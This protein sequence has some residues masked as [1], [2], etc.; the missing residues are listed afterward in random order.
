MGHAGAPRCLICGSG[1]HRV[2][3]TE[4]GTD[5]LRCRECGHV[6]SSYAAD[7]HFDGFWGDEVASDAHF[8]WRTARN[9][10]YDDFT[11][12]FL[13]GRSGRLLDMGCG[14]GFFL[15]RIARLGTWEPYGCEISPA[16][17]RYAREKHGLRNVV[18][19]RLQDVDLPRD[20]FDV[21]TMWDVLEHVLLPDPLLQ[22]CHALL[23][24]GGMCFIRTPNV[25]IQL[26]R[27]RFNTLFGTSETGVG[28]LAREHLHHYSTST[29]RTLLERN[30]FT[31]AGFVHLR[32]VRPGPGAGRFQQSVKR[33]WFQ[34]VRALAVLTG[35]YMNLDN[36]FVVA[37]K[38]PVGVQRQ[39]AA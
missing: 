7:P 21:I 13:A 6:F 2:V 3:F 26:P 19:G 9:P 28:L 17:V 4:D 1:H 20:T 8:Y 33:T 18:C 15:T 25:R 11:R 29:I 39:A 32:P 35:G 22:R 34:A 27:A 38:R 5:V 12:L 10:M 24:D 14:L 36:L 23:R 31:G 16:A 37:H 30:G